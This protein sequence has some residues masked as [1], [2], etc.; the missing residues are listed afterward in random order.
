M[1]KLFFIL[2]LAGSILNLNAQETAKEFK[3]LGIEKYKAKAYAESVEA[4]DKAVEL[5]N[6]EGTVDTTLFYYGAL[7]SNKAKNYEKS[8]RFKRNLIVNSSMRAA[9]YDG[10]E[11]KI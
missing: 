3:K 6:A 2:L 8:K 4:F 11:I 9:V 7:S 1:K 5:N 10:K